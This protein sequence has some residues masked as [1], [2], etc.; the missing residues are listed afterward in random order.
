VLTVDNMATTARS[1][2][3]PASR[4]ARRAAATTGPITPSA[5]T[6]RFGVAYALRREGADFAISAIDYAKS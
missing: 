6:R 2:C 4:D 3:R 5:T 1:S